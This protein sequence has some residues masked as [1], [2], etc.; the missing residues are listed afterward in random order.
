MGDAKTSSGKQASVASPHQNCPVQFAERYASP[1]LIAVV[2]PS[3]PTW[4]ICSLSTV[5]LASAGYGLFAAVF[6]QFLYGI[7][8][9]FLFL[10]LTYFYHL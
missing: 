3:K 7:I 8:V 10:L 2:D 9:L 1:S 4:A 5:Q 6:Q